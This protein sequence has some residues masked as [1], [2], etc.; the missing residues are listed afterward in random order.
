[1]LIFLTLLLV[2]LALQVTKYFLFEVLLRVT[3]KNAEDKRKHHKQ[4]SQI[5]K[6][7]PVQLELKSIFNSTT[8]SETLLLSKKA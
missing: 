7:N 1:M 5:S 6:S 3:E 2:V 8:R 4:L